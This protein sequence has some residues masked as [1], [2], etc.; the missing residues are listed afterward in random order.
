MKRL[1]LNEVKSRIKNVH[2]DKYDLSNVIYKNKRTKIEVICRKHGSWYTLIEILV[3]GSGCPICAGKVVSEM[4]S[5]G[6]NFKNLLEDWDYSKNSLSPYDISYGSNTKVWWKCQKNHSYDMS[7]KL[8]TQKKPQGCP[9]CSN[10]R[11][12]THNSIATLKPEWI[13]EWNYEKNLKRTPHNLGIQSNIKVWWKCKE[14]H[15]WYVSPNNRVS[16]STG[17]PN[18]AKSGFKSDLEG[19]LYLHKVKV[20]KKI[21]LK[22]GV[23][24]YPMQRENQLLKRNS[25]FNKNGDN[26]ILKNLFV[27]RGGGVKILDSERILS[28]NFGG[29]FFSIDEFQDGFSET[30]KYNFLTPFK[31]FSILCNNGL[32]SH[33][34]SITFKLY[35]I[36]K[37]LIN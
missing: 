19:F 20:N 13:S 25:R 30:I 22:Y 12:S 33:K 16:Y 36:L 14:N 32:K 10:M 17:C 7:P 24:N 4:N 26:I 11:V 35:E 3:R 28:R 15:E 9:F 18:C 2:G 27:F 1:D 31:I 37:N 23:T 21:G 8:R 6:Y 34:K 5:L 29:N